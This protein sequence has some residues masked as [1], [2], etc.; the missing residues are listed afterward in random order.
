MLKYK[1]HKK[2]RADRPFLRFIHLACYCFRTLPFG[3]A[4]LHLK[5][6]IM[7]EKHFEKTLDRFALAPSTPAGQV[8]AGSAEG[9]VPVAAKLILDTPNVCPYCQKEMRE[10]TAVNVPVFIC[11]EDRH[12][13]PRPNETA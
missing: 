2:R 9:A 4:V 7:S 1:K 5:A 6:T 12:V 3:S 8:S 13:V 11:D 10:S